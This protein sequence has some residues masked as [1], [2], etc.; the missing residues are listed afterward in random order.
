MTKSVNW[1][2]VLEKFEKRLSDLKARVLSFGGQL[3]LINSVL[4]SLPLYF[5]SLFRAPPSVLHKLECAR[6]IELDN[7]GINFTKAFKKEIGNG[8]DTRFWLDSWLIDTPLCERFSRLF[9]LDPVPNTSVQ[10]RLM[11]SGEICSGSW[12]WVREPRGRTDAEL[13]ELMRLLQDFST[14]NSGD[15]RWRW[16]LGANETVAHAIFQCQNEVWNRVYDWFGLSRVTLNLSNAFLGRT[17]IQSTEEGARVWQ[18]VEWTCDYLIWKNR[19]KKVFKNSSWNPP[20]A[21]N[22]IQI[23][24][25]EWISKRC[26]TLEIDWHS[27]LTNPKKFIM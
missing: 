11:R 4:N 26:K 24:S 19:N 17:S 12:N 14:N 22:E 13:N 21:L 2:P 9:R 16:S 25:F 10:D 23:K 1:K 27:W 5:F 18:A 8:K 7:L 3:T 20:V 6:R 15:D